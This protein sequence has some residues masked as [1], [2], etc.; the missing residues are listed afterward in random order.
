MNSFI[1]LEKA[2]YIHYKFNA[3][4]MSII[5]LGIIIFMRKIAPCKLHANIQ[6]NNDFS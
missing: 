1:L 2:I 6:N 5:I 4:P 3:K